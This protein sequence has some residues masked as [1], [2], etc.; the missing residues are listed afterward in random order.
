MTRMDLASSWLNSNAPKRQK[1]R[2]GFGIKRRRPMFHCDLDREAF[3]ALVAH[4]VSGK[5]V[6]KRRRPFPRVEQHGLEGED[7]IRANVDF[8]ERRCLL[9]PYHRLGSP[10]AVVVNTI[11]MPAARLMC[12]LAHGEPGP[13][14]VARHLCGRGHISC[15]NPTHLC[16]G[17]PQENAND[18]ALHH[19][20]PK[21]APDLDDETVSGI[22]QDDRHYNIVAVDYNLPSAVILAIQSGVL[23]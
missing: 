11:T 9:M 4:E 5:R 6:G 21:F 16:W 8:A 2:S 7:F 10:S 18:T 17:S 19:S 1:K 12:R 23:R 20:R 15:V 22:E 13:G 14:E 3:E